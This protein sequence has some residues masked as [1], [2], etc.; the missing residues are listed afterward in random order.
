[1]N[2]GLVLTVVVCLYPIVYLSLFAY[3]WNGRET[4]NRSDFK[5]SNLLSAVGTGALAI[6]VVVA[7]L[8]GAAALLG[9]G[10]YWLLPQPLQW[11]GLWA[12]VTLVMLIPVMLLRSRGYREW[13]AEWVN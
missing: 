4:G 1:M 8:A 13:I 5:V 2:L 12:V 9:F 6:P 3:W 11:G 10:A 7:P